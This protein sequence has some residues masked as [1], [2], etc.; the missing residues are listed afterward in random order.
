MQEY[1]ASDKLKTHQKKLLY[2]IRTRMIETPDSYGRNE[3]CKLCHLARDDMSHVL[4][5]IVIK[6]A[7]PLAVSYTH[8]TLPTKA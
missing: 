5:C 6:L 2:K 8:L 4:D 7:S 3:L 1:L